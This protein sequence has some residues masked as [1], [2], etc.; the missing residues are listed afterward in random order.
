MG[1]FGFIVS[2]ASL[3]VGCLLYYALVVYMA[4]VVNKI[5]VSSGFEL[6]LVGY[7]GVSGTCKF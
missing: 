3:L 2:Q 5:Q 7:L 4:W 1:E 6:M